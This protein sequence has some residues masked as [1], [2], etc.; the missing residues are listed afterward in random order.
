MNLTSLP[1]LEY[2]NII[3]F[4]MTCH[5]TKVLLIMMIN[6]TSLSTVPLFSRSHVEPQVDLALP[7]TLS[8]SST[9]PSNLSVAIGTTAR[10]HCTVT[11]VEKEAVSMSLLNNVP[12]LV[13]S[14]DLVDPPL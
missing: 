12:N 8:S 9:I 7:A 3:F 10:L 14:P 2:D 13:S 11:N 4:Q 6:L 5:L 1:I